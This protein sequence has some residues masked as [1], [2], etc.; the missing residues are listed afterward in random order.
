MEQPHESTT[1]IIEALKLIAKNQEQLLQRT[2]KLLEAQK[3]NHRSPGTTSKI[4]IEV[5]V[6]S[7]QFIKGLYT[8]IIQY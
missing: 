5:K 7:K 1:N 8:G 4:P 6:K 2:S 3:S